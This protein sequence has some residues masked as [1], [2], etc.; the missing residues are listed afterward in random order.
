MSQI[1][2]L[3]NLQP[4]PDETIVEFETLFYDFLWNGKTHKVKKSIITQRYDSGGQSMIDLKSVTIG[5]EETMDT[6]FR[7]CLGLRTR[8]TILWTSPHTR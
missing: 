4:F 3:A 2:H 7:E 1:I 6:V 5:T 8:S